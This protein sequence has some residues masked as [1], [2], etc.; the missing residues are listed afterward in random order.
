MRLIENSIIKKLFINLVIFGAI[1]AGLLYYLFFYRDD[2]ILSSFWVVLG[3]LAVF[4]V[5]FVLLYLFYIVFPFRK[6]L[7][8]MQALLAGKSFKK[9]Y[10]N[11][12]D[13]VGV[14]AHFFNKVTE[15]FGK[16]SSDIKDRKRMLDELNVAS[17]LQKDIMPTKNP[18]IPGLTVVAK[19]KPCSELGGDTFNFVGAN[20]KTYIYVGDV[21]GHGAASGLI[22]TMVHSLITVFSDIYDS[23][24]DVLV[25]VN[26]YL[27]RWIKKAMYMTLVMLCWDE[28][29]NKM[30]YVGAGHEHILIYRAD[31]GQCESI[32][33]GGIAL[34]MLPD[35][36]KVIKEKEI[37]LNDGDFVVLYT[38]G[39]TEAKNEKGELYGL[40]RL[41]KAVQ[42]FAKQ[43]GP[44]GVNSRIA[45][46]VTVFMGEHPQEDDMTLIVIKKK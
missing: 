26:K 25:Q 41:E 46:E 22:M 4:T 29:T 39:I 28:K 12:I 34:G 30:T 8:Q 45:K 27:K 13:E 9:I 19:T 42:E 10:T 23:P 35:N 11:R 5:Y 33:S 15:G 32:V 17:Q 43:Y 14:M 38:D 40:S 36:S 18:E 6:I 7:A 31:T 44:E 3:G 37:I 24:Y 21:T 2:V 16:V 1:I 20:G